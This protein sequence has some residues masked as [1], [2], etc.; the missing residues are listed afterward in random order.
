MSHNFKNSDVDASL[1]YKDDGKSKLLVLVY[2]DDIVITGSLDS[3]ISLFIQ[4][5]CE[6]FQCIHGKIEFLS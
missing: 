4:K 6:N 2:V 5:I 3:E 1:F